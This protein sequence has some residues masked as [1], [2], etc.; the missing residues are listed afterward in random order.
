[1]DLLFGDKDTK[2]EMKR[3]SRNTS[4]L[5]SKWIALVPRRQSS[6]WGAKNQLRCSV[7][8]LKSCHN[9]GRKQGD[10]G[11]RNTGL[12]YW[13]N[14]DSYCTMVSDKRGFWDTQ[15][16]SG[17]AL[18]FL[19]PIIKIS[20]LWETKTRW[21]NIWSLWELKIRP[22]CLKTKVKWTKA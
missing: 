11:G 5:L 4:S 19:C 13:G 20:E 14:L 15:L 9:E 1:M 21:Q 3:S 22:P 10:M 8:I 12:S 2:L 16:F 17:N 6:H 7:A 18:V